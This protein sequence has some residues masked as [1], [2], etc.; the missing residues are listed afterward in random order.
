MIKVVQKVRIDKWLWAVRLYK[1]RTMAAD[2]CKG[3][4]VKINGDNVKPS[5]DVSCGEEVHVSVG[6][7][8]KII[9]VDNLSG[10]RMAAA[11]VKDFYTD[12]TPPE[13]YEK[14]KIHRI[15]KSELRPLGLGRPTKKERRDIDRWK[16][17]L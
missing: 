15:A 4:K 1:T 3:G 7:I 5:R 14:E 8:V 11:L 10:N 12:L 2:A 6:I 16:W 9:R 17:A 13:E